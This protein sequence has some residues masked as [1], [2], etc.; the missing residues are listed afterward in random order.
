MPRPE[1]E[2]V[3]LHGFAGSGA[4]LRR[5]DVSTAWWTPDLVGHGR[6]GALRVASFDA[7]VERL[8]GLRHRRQRRRRVLVG[9]SLGAR[10]GLRW[11][12]RFPGA[13]EALVLVGVAPGLADPHARSARTAQDAAWVDVL[14]AQGIGEFAA[15]WEALPLFASQQRVSPELRRWQR[16]VRRSQDPAGLAHAL[17]V[18]G[19]GAMPPLTPQDCSRLAL[20]VILVAGADDAKF[21][22]LARELAPRLVQAQV[23]VVPNCGHNVALEAPVEL[24]GVIRNV[25]GEVKRWRQ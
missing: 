15:R 17:E 16:Q 20:P 22:A 2:V 12:C 14:I 7:E 11:A 18:L 13:F 4:L 24:A 19:L 21:V 10:V 3:G 5:L 25:I 9:Y 1:I 23:V 6:R 8:E